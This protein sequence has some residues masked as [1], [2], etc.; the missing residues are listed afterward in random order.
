[1]VAY[2]VQAHPFNRAPSANPQMITTRSRQPASD[3]EATGGSSRSSVWSVEIDHGS[4]G[5]L[6]A[7]YGN[8]DLADDRIWHLCFGRDRERNDTNSDE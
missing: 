2:D 3:T 7:Y 6:S 5:C 4:C 8:F 1:M